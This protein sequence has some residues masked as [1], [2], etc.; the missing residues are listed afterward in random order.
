MDYLNTF[1][2]DLSQ[3]LLQPWT[4][5]FSHPW[6]FWLQAI[7]VQSVDQLEQVVIALFVHRQIPQFIDDDQI[8]LGKTVD[9]LFELP[10]VFKPS[11][12]RGP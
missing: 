5:Y 1:D 3:A 4:E 7:L 10:F 6:K 8:E 9:L 12:P 11:T 2:A